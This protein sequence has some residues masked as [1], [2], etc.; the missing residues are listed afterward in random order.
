MSF[1]AEA[2]R[3]F[4]VSADVAFDCLAD[5]DAWPRWMPASFRPVG[6]SVG[7]L[8]QGSRFRVRILGMPMTVPIRVTKSERGRELTW[9]GGVKG[10]FL[11]DHRFLFEPKGDS[12]VE[13]RSV[14]T[15][16]GVLASLTQRLLLPQAERIGR[17]QLGGLAAAIETE[18][19]RS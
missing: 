13:V 12:S 19:T 5:H 3:T 14:E 7:R 16:S 6:R 2:S 11:A 8:S 17:D 4:P 1:V 18:P 15:W 10:V 9:G